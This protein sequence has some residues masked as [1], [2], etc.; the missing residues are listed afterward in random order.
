MN[1]IVLSDG[2]FQKLQQE[3]QLYC[4][5]YRH[6]LQ[7]DSYAREVLSYNGEY[8]LLDTRRQDPRE[9]GWL[10]TMI[11]RD[12]VLTVREDLYHPGC[13]FALGARPLED[14]ERG[15]RLGQTILLPGSW[16][17][18][19][20]QEAQALKPKGDG[21][22]AGIL[23]Q[24]KAGAG[25][26]HAFR[27]KWAAWDLYN[28][29]LSEREEARAKRS[30]AAVKKAVLENGRFT[31]H[32]EK[33][34][35]EY[36][37]GLTLGAHFVGDREGWFTDLGPIEAV[38]AAAGLLEAPCGDGALL[39]EILDG[40]RGKME[41]V[42]TVDYGARARLRR[43][44]QAME[45]LFREE[46]ANPRLKSILMGA[47]DF[48]PLPDRAETAEAACGLFGSN[49]RQQEAYAGAVRAEDIYLI[50]GPPGT[51]KTTII[52]EIVK[53]AVQQ[54]LQVLVSSET[55][56]AVD[57]V[58]ERV[59]S[60]E[61]VI[62]VRLGRE[63]RISQSALP[64]TPQNIARSILR[65]TRERIAA[66]ERGWENPDTIAN[67]LREEYRRKEEALRKEIAS[68]RDRLPQGVDETQMLEQI[69]R[70]EQL[71]LEI[72]TLY[73]ALE[74][75]RRLYR[76]LKGQEQEL[77]ARKASLEARIR[78][79]GQE[80]KGRPEAL[81]WA[82]PHALRQE[83]TQA[84][85]A[86]CAV[87]KQLRQN[88]CEAHSGA[89]QRK[90]RRSRKLREAL[91]ALVG[92]ERP[93]MGYIHRLREL[94]CEI[95]DLER[96]CV[97]LREEAAE[98]IREALSAYDRKKALWE[99]SATL[100][101]AWREAVQGREV[102]QEIETIYLK[103]ANV[104]FSTCTGFA[105][106][107]NGAFADMEYDYVLID[108]AAKCSLLDLL[109]PLA[110]GRKIILVGD[111]KQLYPIVELDSTDEEFTEEQLQAVREHILFKWLYEERV[112]AA[113]KTML[114]RQYRMPPDIAEFVSNR[115]YGGD[116]L[117]EKE[118]D[119][120]ALFWLDS[121]G[122]EEC[123][124]GSSYENPAEARL[125][126]QLVRR[127]DQNAPAGRTLGIICTY[128]AQA[129]LLRQELEQ[130]GPERL[131]VECSTVDAFQGKEKH[132][133]IFNLVRS[134]RMTAFGSDENRVNVAV[135][136]AQER[137]Y[138]VG[139]AAAVKRSRGGALRDL[140][141]YTVSRGTV[142][143][144]QGGQENDSASIRGT[145]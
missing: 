138:I 100:R 37:E 132:T 8:R 74:E 5:R 126:L 94:V 33:W 25:E 91:A 135:S 53:Y 55:N 137:L 69:A 85:Q 26:F 35:K 106:R 70:Y 118:A 103:K 32:V 79:C 77:A 122:S 111:H 93:F 89:Y 140:Y 72:N 81:K 13:L 145:I 3:Y 66:M 90:L 107:D 73:D 101:Q 134:S 7:F 105:S 104:V 84:E 98:K 80:W 62:P 78:L 133:V 64:F 116:V 142:W 92:E 68:L 131:D 65:E 45:K 16:Q 87:Q 17:V 144:S 96:Q 34:R 39:R 128:R 44:R 24:V 40:A 102:Q 86:L 6:A 11:G 88:G 30:E 4:S 120:R 123:R 46:T 14:Q 48:P 15:E 119:G 22:L 113:Y 27:E 52:T 51:G 61:Q 20:A 56:I 21:T 50:Q 95:Q 139:S 42:R 57:N 141:D 83:L 19:T 10:Y 136:R 28:R 2:S 12:W 99:R 63:E 47:Y 129:E 29:K 9:Q 127:L 143:R 58:L 130:R 1:Y 38:N 110:A 124:R 125:V 117:C 71:V 18:L 43:Q 108:E 112:P 31:I 54:G 121:E 76:S 49:L 75:E 109:I 59:H 97:G 82:D 67:A 60:L 23:R 36:E 41:T 114:N 115:F